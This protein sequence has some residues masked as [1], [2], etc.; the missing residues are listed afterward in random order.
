MAFASGPGA[1]PT[2]VLAFLAPPATVTVG[3]GQSVHVTSH[4]A[5]GTTVPGGAAFLNLWICRAPSP[6]GTPLTQVGGGVLGNQVA[7]NTRIPMGLS[8][9]ITPPPGAYQVGL[10]G[11]TS[12]GNLNWNSNEFGYTSAIVATT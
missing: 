5:L 9:V 12:D 4:K 8:A 1:S 10:C 6:A 3:T 2:L 7:Q 11:Q